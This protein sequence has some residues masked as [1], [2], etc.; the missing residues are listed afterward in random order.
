[1]NKN[2]WYDSWMDSFKHAK[3]SR[4]TFIL[5]NDQSNFDAQIAFGY[6]FNSLSE[7]ENPDFEAF[8]TRIISNFV[9]WTK[10][11]KD[12]SDILESA[13]NAGFS[14]GNTG[15]IESVIKAHNTKEFPK[16]IEE[17]IKSK[18]LNQ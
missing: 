16:D 18:K 9:E 7:N 14:I 13:T 4:R 8:I 15:I 10:L 17:E 5:G 3:A 12:F 6:Y 1:M 11:K 2:D